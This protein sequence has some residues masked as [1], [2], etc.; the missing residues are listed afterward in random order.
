[1]G[2]SALVINDSHGRAGSLRQFLFIVCAAAL[3][4]IF[5]WQGIKDSGNPRPLED[6]NHYSAAFDIGVLVFRE[7]LECVL[8]L[9]AITAGAAGGQRVL[10]NAIASG[11]GL[12]SMATI[13]TWFIAV[14]IL[15]DLT[16]NFSALAVQAA[17]GLLAVIVLLVVMNWFF[18]RMYWTGWISYHNRR[19]HELLR[20]SSSPLSSRGSFFWGMALLGFTSLY[21]EGFEVVLFLQSYRLRLGNAAVLSGVCIGLFLSGIVAVLVFIA[22]K[23]LPY[24]K[25][26]VLTGIL[27]GLVLIVMVGEQ[28]QEMQQARWLSTTT[29]PAFAKYFPDWAGIWFSIYPTFESLAAQ[30]VSACVV[31]GSYVMANRK[32]A[33]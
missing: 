33:A 10:R 22:H 9:A 18:H 11:V 2:N 28:V 27:L 13:T 25:M 30:A 15:D 5:F 21:R 24:R 31:V 6:A 12:G 19:K 23:K 7:G 3:L 1:M 14:R 17:T 20:E 26:L 4:A 16:L 8:V 29:I 32:N